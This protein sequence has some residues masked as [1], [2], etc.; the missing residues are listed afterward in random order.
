MLYRVRSLALSFLKFKLNTQ[1]SRHLHR[2]HP[3]KF[4]CLLPKPNWKYDIGV[5]AP[6]NFSICI[7][8]MTYVRLTSFFTSSWD[9]IHQRTHSTDRQIKEIWVWG[10]QIGFSSPLPH[11]VTRKTGQGQSGTFTA[12][13]QMVRDQFELQ[14]GLGGTKIENLWRTL[15]VRNPKLDRNITDFKGKKRGNARW[16]NARTKTRK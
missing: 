12:Y 11:L 5:A 2:T 3:L 8:W 15:L 16:E 7:W 9:P 4:V 1:K 14:L 10:S 13:A 6:S